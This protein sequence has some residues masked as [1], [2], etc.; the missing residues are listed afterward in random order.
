[1]EKGIERSL[2]RCGRLSGFVKTRSGI[3]ETSEICGI[4]TNSATPKSSF[5]TASGYFALGL[6]CREKPL[7]DS[8]VGFHG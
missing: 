3:R 7:A 6:S 5:E 4:L 1:M 2:G 8:S